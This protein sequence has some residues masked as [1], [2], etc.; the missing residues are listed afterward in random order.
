[1]QYYKLAKTPFTRY[2][3]LSYRLNNRLNNRLHRVNIHSTGCSTGCSTH[4]NKQC[5]RVWN[6]LPIVLASGH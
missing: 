6:S 5:S 2:N 3:R 1:M 4:V